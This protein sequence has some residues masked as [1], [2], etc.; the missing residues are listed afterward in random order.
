MGIFPVNYAEQMPEPSAAALGGEAEQEATLLAQV[1]E[2]WQVGLSLAVAAA[3]EKVNVGMEGVWFKGMIDGPQ[4]VWG[5]A[6]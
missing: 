4:G 6:W 1:L 5:S 2:E 3:S